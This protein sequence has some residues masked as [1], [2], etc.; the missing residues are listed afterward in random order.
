MRFSRTPSRKNFAEWIL[1]MS[2]L[3]LRRKSS[4][5]RKASSVFSAEMTLAVAATR[6]VRAPAV[7][8]A[9]NAGM[10]LIYGSINHAGNAMAIAQALREAHAIGVIFVGWYGHAVLG[11]VCCVFMEHAGGFAAASRTNGRFRGRVCRARGLSFHRL[12]N[13]C[14]RYAHRWRRYGRAC[15]ALLHQGRGG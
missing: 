4:R 7:P 11:P 8:A 2:E 1:N 3:L 9:V 10:A 13:S 12:W 14:R 5:R 6:T 15:R